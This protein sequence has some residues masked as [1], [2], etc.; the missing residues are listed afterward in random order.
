M[1]YY[2]NIF[3]KSIY[4][5]LVILDIYLEIYLLSVLWRSLKI[6][7]VTFLI[8]FVRVLSS[9]TED[10]LN[11]IIVRSLDSVVMSLPTELEISVWFLAPPKD[12]SLVISFDFLIFFLVMFYAVFGE[13]PC[14]LL[15]TC[16]WRPYNYIRI[17]IWGR[18]NFFH[19]RALPC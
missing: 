15:T 3:N 1:L 19:Y 17:T 2:R 10:L 11:S 12:Y 8:T 9:E 6:S 14:T 18:R 13:D 7:H 5:S 4:H 16:E